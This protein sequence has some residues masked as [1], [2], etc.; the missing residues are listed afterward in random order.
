MQEQLSQVPVEEQTPELREKIFNNFFKSESHGYVRTMGLGP[1]PAS[2]RSKNINHHDVSNEFM[3]SIWK[4]AEM[5]CM[6]KVNPIL[7]KMQS[8]ID[9]LTKEL[10]NRKSPDNEVNLSTDICTGE[11]VSYYLLEYFFL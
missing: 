9:S 10:Q 11:Q 8:Q 7:E 3:Q 1:T 5:E 4:K 6:K 2:M